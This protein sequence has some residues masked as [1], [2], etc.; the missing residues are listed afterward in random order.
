MS[1]RY[2]S[3]ISLVVLSVAVLSVAACQPMQPS[4]QPVDLSMSSDV[5]AVPVAPVAKKYS[6]VVE[7]LEDRIRA[8]ESQMK[9]AQPKLQKVDAM[10]S[11]FKSLSLQ[12]DRIAT[13][14]DVPMEAPPLVA[15]PLA[16]VEKQIA[17]KPILQKAD[18]K[19]VSKPTSK[20]VV[21]KILEP[22]PVTLPSTGELAVTSVRIGEQSKS[23]TRIVLDTTKP[24]EIRYDLDNAEG[25]LVID[26]PNA[27]WSAS[28]SRE[29]GKSGMVK[30]FRASSDNDGSHLILDLKGNA[31]VVATARLSPSGASGNRVYVDIAPA[32]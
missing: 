21:K 19:P 3:S 20:P 26:V 5:S 23:I 9:D 28:N 22:A 27:K 31:K 30:S 29:V 18:A 8:L 6:S 32:K 17:P 15:K 13:T 11:G 14:Y 10:E 24:A 12:L 7:R 4:G 16:S 25:L 2:Y 1:L